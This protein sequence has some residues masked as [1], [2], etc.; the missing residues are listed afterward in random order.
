MESATRPGAPG[1]SCRFIIERYIVVENTGGDDGV[2]T[3]LV[4][5]SKTTSLTKA[6]EDLYRDLVRA[7]CY[8]RVSRTKIGV[9]L[10]VMRAGEEKR[11]IALASLLAVL[12]LITVYISGLS[13][14]QERHG[15]AWSPVGYLLGLLVPLIIH[16]SGHYF[17]MKKYM[18]PRSLPYLLPAP[19]LQ[20]GFIGTFGAVINM[21]WLPPRNRHLAVIGIAGPIAG[22]LAA[23][24]VA[25]YGMMNSVIEPATG[26]AS[27][28]IAPLIMLLL[29]LPKTPGPGEVVVLSPMAFSAYIVFFVTFLNLVP[30]AMLDGGHVVRSLLG[31]KGHV[32]VSQLTLTALL[33]GSLFYPGL[34]LFTIIVLAL[35]LL[36]KGQHPGSAI[37]DE[38]IDGVSAA[39]GLVYAILLILTLPV[40]A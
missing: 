35:H 23:L 5:D 28:P 39:V 16:E 25:Y 7:G 6:L 37:S 8:M 1:S 29:P 2:E 33:I 24:P 27:L 20:M 9:I 18:V 4:L 14:P 38:E 10:Q 30:V 31:E 3:Y 12:T 34:L 36:S 32:I 22:F 15:L 26:L 11:R 21:R 13:F 40:P 19:P 17:A